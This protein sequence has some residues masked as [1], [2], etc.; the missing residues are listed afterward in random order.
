MEDDD[1]GGGPL[2]KRP[3]VSVMGM[4][5]L[6]GIPCKEPRAVIDFKSES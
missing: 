2:T 6:V 1:S 3:L 4:C 5:F